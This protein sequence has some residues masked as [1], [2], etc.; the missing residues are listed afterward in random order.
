MSKYVLRLLQILDLEL[1]LI[2]VSFSLL[3]FL[4]D[5]EA[6]LL[7]HVD[8]LDLFLE[9]GFYCAFLIACNLHQFLLLFLLH[10]DGLLLLFHLFL[11]CLVLV[12]LFNQVL[13]VL[14]MLLLDLNNLILVVVLQAINLFI[15]HIFQVFSCLF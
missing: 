6:F 2:E 14:S 3:E 13:S 12:V 1:V 15:I 4:S 5:L 8:L 7:K 10:L 11:L 9:L